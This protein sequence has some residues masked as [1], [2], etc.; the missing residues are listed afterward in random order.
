M[1]TQLEGQLKGNLNPWFS[2]WTKPRATMQKIYQSK[3]GY[4]FLLFLT[5]ALVQ[6]LDRASLRN[7]GDSMSLSELMVISVIGS[8]I[9]ATTYYYLI[10][11]LLCWTGS[12]IGGRGTTE[13]VRYSVAYSNIPMVYSL[14]IVWLPSLFLFGIENFTTF[15]PVVDSS[16]TSTLLLM[17]FGLVDLVIGIW[18]A[19]I[20]LKCLGEAHQFSAWKALLTTFLSVLIVVVPFIIIGVL[21]FSIG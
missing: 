7:S 15:T 21:V 18:S 19:I 6:V 1:E 17:L 12:K 10:P 2:I 11:K 13:R 16:S 3:P 14:I 5:G 9:V 4:V 8:L 20:F